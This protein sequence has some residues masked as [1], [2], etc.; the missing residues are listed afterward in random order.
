MYFYFQILP[1][2]I[3]LT[4]PESLSEEDIALDTKCTELVDAYINTFSSMKSQQ[5]LALQGFREYYQQLVDL[6]RGLKKAHGN[7]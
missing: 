1:R 4:K 7:A 2:P 5:A 6:S 3:Q